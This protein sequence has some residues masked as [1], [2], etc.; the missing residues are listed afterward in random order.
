MVDG[1]I[2]GT[3]GCDQGVFEV[4]PMKN[5]QWQINCILEKSVGEI[6]WCDIDNDGIDEMMTIEPFHGD[7]MKIYKSTEGKYS[8]SY[9]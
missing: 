3:F 8:E 6:A 9:S 1:K 2:H 5:E 7:S 4:V